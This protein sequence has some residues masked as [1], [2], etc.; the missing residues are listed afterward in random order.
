MNNNM[1]EDSI[2]SFFKS[3]LIGDKEKQLIDLI[4]KNTDCET[5][6]KI[7]LLNGEDVSD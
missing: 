7:L 2:D 6:F 5:L 3:L 4:S 1:K